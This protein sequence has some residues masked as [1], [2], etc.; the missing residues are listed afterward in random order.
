MEFNY[1][2]LVKHH[3]KILQLIE[4]NLEGLSAFDFT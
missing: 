1:E 3:Q 4:S 2:T